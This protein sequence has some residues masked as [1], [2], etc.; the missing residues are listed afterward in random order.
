MLNDALKINFHVKNEEQTQIKQIKIINEIGAK[1]DNR[2]LQ[3]NGYTFF[4]FDVLGNII[5]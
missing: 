2:Q 4:L 5:K 3:H 1:I